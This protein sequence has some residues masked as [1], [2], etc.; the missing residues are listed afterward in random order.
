MSYFGGSSGMVGDPGFFG[1]FASLIKRGAKVGLGFL[2][3]GPVGAAGAAASFVRPARSRLR[4]VPQRVVPTPG[5]VAAGQRLIPGGATGLQIEGVNGRRRKRM[6]FGNTKALR[7]A[8]RR[9]DGFIRLVKTS[10]KNTDM[11]L[12]SKSAGKLTADQ[13]R[14]KQHHAT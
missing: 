4:A 13:W 9:T 12:V 7:R 14:R 11:K 2:G 1:S 3:G 8:T 5:I 6:D 10:L